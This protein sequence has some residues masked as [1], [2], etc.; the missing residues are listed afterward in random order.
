MKEL[1]KQER[2]VREL[3]RQDQGK[4]KESVA[5][6][7]KALATKDLEETFSFGVLWFPYVNTLSFFSCRFVCGVVAFYF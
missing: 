3:T 2:E 6:G 4:K 5:S 7:L 1:T